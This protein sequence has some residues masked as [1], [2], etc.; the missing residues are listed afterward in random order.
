MKHEY[1][2][3]RTKTPA[4]NRREQRRLAAQVQRLQAYALKGISLIE[5]YAGASTLSKKEQEDL[6]AMGAALFASYMSSQSPLS[7]KRGAITAALYAAFRYG[8]STV[9]S[10]AQGKGKGKKHD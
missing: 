6:G 4:L 2:P 8:R 3:S 5:T 9:N 7:D 1:N 10:N